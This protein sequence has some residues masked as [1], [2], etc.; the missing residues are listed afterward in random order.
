MKLKE[1][2][3]EN[4]LAILQYGSS[5]DETKHQFSDIDICIVAPG[6]IKEEKEKITRENSI[7]QK[8]DI[9]FFEDLPVILKNEIIIKNKPIYISDE[10]KLFEY[11][12]YWKKI[13][14]NFIPMHKTA[15]KTISERLK[16]WKSKKK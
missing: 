8:T 13:Y 15:K 11:F 14:Q 4:I 3:N 12:L 9:K 7:D 1:I 10:I 2:E 16:I 6:I 5:V